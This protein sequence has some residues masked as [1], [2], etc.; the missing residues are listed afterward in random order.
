MCVCGGVCVGGGGA[1]HRR[2]QRDACLSHARSHL[3][4]PPPRPPRL[5]APAGVV[6][7]ARWRDDHCFASCGND[8][9]LV[10]VDS[11]QPTSTGGWENRNGRVRNCER[12]IGHGVRGCSFEGG[13]RLAGAVG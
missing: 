7:C 13:W 8:R 1:K 2:E 5:R 12:L 10:V 6:K 4:P 11:R 9:R 3:P